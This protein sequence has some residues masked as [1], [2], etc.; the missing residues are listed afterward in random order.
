[1]LFELLYRAE[2]EVQTEDLVNQ[3][4]P[5]LGKYLRRKSDDSKP[6]SFS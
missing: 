3:L 5:D 1:M 4:S 2:F 6:E